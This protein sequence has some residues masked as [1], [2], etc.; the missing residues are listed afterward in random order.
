LRLATT[1]SAHAANLSVVHAHELRSSKAQVLLAFSLHLDDLIFALGRHLRVHFSSPIA[2]HFLS[3]C[4][5]DVGQ[6]S[7]V[8]HGEVPFI[9]SAL[10]HVTLFQC[11]KFLAAFISN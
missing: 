7:K 5:A 11:S 8:R 6:I 4:L 3:L 9:I 2:K 10:A 1:A